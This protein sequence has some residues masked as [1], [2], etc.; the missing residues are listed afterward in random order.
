[1]RI[2]RS[3]HIHR[4]HLLAEKPEKPNRWEF[5]PYKAG[6]LFR[7][8]IEQK[9]KRDDKRVYYLDERFTDFEDGGVCLERSLFDYSCFF[10]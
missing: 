3:S 1:M 5:N 4:T 8:F 6:K 7:E 9:S 2:R 10:I